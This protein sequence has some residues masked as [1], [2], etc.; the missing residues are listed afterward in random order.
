[1]TVVEMTALAR[2]ITA[3][4]AKKNQADGHKGW[5][6]EQYMSGFVGD[7]GD[8]QKLVMA[9]VGYRHYD[10]VDAKLAHELSDCLW[11]ILVIADQL[12]IDIEAVYRQ[13]MSQLLAEITNP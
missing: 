10:D 8:L 1:M 12:N 11:S 7:V 9:K 6:L 3:A 2:Q 5:A 13:N 4:Y